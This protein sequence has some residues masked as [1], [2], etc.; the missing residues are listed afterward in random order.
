MV[1]QDLQTFSYSFE[2]FKISSTLRCQQAKMF[3]S[4]GKSGK[5]GMDA[6]VGGE[7]VIAGTFI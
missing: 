2:H 7:E 3:D 6:D 5:N 1:D 4:Q